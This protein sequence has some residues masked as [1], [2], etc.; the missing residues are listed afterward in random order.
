M[1]KQR[2]AEEKK[3]KNDAWRKSFDNDEY[4]KYPGQNHQSSP[5]GFR[6]SLISFFKPAD[7]DQ[8]FEAEDGQHEDW[9]NSPDAPQEFLM[10]TA[11][12]EDKL[13]PYYITKDAVSWTCKDVAEKKAEKQF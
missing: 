1:I 3:K 8:F 5:T 6:N 12:N 4:I 13:D 2:E 10:P 7:I 9:E 11:S